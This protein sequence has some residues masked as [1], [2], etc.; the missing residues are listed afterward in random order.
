MSISQNGWIDNV[1]G[2]DWLKNCF[3]PSTSSHNVGKFRLLI[4]DGH[5][6]HLTPEFDQICK[7]HDIIPLCMP[8]H[9]SHLLQ[10]LDVDCFSILKRAYQTLVQ[11][12]CRK[13]V[14][15]IDKHD[16]LLFYPQARAK[17]FKSDICQAAF[18]GTGLVP[19]DPERVISKLNIKLTLRSAS[20]GFLR[21]YAFWYY[22]S[23]CTETIEALDTC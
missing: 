18:A 23:L 20:K 16:L 7:K 21:A 6:S 13:G 8:A 14:N 15:H 5:D 19:L 3:I 17:T 12:L 22:E 2:L 4:L 9:A 1:I 10:P 11:D